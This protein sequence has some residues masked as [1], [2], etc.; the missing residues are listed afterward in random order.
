[1]SGGRS[2]S[3]YQEKITKQKQHSTFVFGFSHGLSVD[4]PRPH[5][6]SCSH[7]VLPL[8]HP[9]LLWCAFAQAPHSP[10]MAPR[11]PPPSPQ[12]FNKIPNLRLRPCFVG[13][14]QFVFCMMNMWISGGAHTFPECSSQH[15][16]VFRLC[17]SQEGFASWCDV[18][19]LAPWVRNL[20]V[21]WK[22]DILSQ[23]Y[24]SSRSP[25]PQSRP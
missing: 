14:F 13:F 11:P 7:S 24:T 25:S 18:K 22:V 21:Q 16:V 5:P 9:P 3:L 23:S 8:S 1:M 17:S 12:H 15:F 19:S 2:R 20:S 10:P 4:N 6:M